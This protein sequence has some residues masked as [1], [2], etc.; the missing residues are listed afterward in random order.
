MIRGIHYNIKM[1]YLLDTAV[2]T[3]MYSLNYLKLFNL[4]DIMMDFN[5]F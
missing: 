2:R 1:V 5:D 4:H 3:L